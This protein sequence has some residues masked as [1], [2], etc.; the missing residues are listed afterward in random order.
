MSGD[1]F[2]TTTKNLSLLFGICLGIVEKA[3]SQR[4]AENMKALKEI[5]IRKAVK[6]VCLTIVMILYKMMV[7]PQLR[8]FY[9]RVLGAEVGK[10]A[11]IHNVG[12]FKKVKYG[13]GDNLIP[14]TDLAATFFEWTS[15]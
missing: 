10:N 13:G 9:I 11:I 14:F 1:H 5:G 7:L 3:K 6:F 12:F 2:C 8:V 15:D 4:Y